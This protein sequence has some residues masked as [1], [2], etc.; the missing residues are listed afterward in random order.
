M[1]ADDLI[2]LLQPHF[3]KAHLQAANQGNKFEVLIVDAV[4]EGKRPVQRQQ[5]VYAIVNPHIQSGAMHAL[6]IHALTP[7]EYNTKKGQ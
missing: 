1:N 6:T 4:F 3:P 2:E 5:A 7:D